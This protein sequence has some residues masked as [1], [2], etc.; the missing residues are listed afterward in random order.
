MLRDLEDRLTTGQKRPNT[1]VA[2][3]PLRLWLEACEPEG[4]GRWAG[5]NPTVGARRLR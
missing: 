4:G 1:V 3:Q 2:V 5:G